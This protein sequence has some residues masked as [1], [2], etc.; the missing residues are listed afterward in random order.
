MFFLSSNIIADE[1]RPKRR[2]SAAA[3]FS[4]ANADPLDCSGPELSE[5]SESDDGDD[6]AAPSDSE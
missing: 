5:E 4:K 2:R 6:Y 1:G 3:N